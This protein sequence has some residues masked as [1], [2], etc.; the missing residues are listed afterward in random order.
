MQATSGT[1][2]DDVLHETLNG[3]IHTSS[4]LLESDSEDEDEDTDENDGPDA[5]DPRATVLGRMSRSE[6]VGRVRRPSLYGELFGM[7]PVQYSCES[8]IVNRLR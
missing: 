5:T 4:K 8:N 3:G 6:P 1:I 2:Y 7:R